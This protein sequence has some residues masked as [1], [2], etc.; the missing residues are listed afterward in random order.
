[1]DAGNLTAIA[2]MCAAGTLKLTESQI[3][4]F[5][6]EVVKV[7]SKILPNFDSIFAKKIKISLLLQSFRHFATYIQN[8]KY[9]ETSK[10]TMCYST[11]RVK[12]S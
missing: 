10:L 3:A 11:V 1:M 4:Y 7:I 9:I 12:L 8:I 5:V 2:D 6:G